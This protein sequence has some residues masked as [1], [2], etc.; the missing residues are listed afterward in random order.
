VPIFELIT[1][2]SKP[3]LQKQVLDDGR[4]WYHNGGRKNK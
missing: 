3:K 2:G 1:L 4:E